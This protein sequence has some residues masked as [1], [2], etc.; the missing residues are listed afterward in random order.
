MN[1][2]FGAEDGDLLLFVADKPK[3]VNDALGKLRTRSPVHSDF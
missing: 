3:V 1:T 2:S